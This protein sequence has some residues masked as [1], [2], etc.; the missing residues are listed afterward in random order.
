MNF[1][2]ALD[3]YRSGLRAFLNGVNNLAPHFSTNEPYP[4]QDGGVEEDDKLSRND[5]EFREANRGELRKVHL[6]VEQ[7]QNEF[8]IKISSSEFLT[9]VQKDNLKSHIENIHFNYKIPDADF[10]K[11]SF[12]IGE[13]LLETV[14]EISTQFNERFN[15]YVF[16]GPRNE[17]YL[18]DPVDFFISYRNSR[19]TVNIPFPFLMYPYFDADQPMS[20][21][22]GALGFFIGHEIGHSI[23]P[24]S[25]YFDEDSIDV[26][27]K[28]KL[29]LISQ[30]DGYSID[31]GN[32]DGSLTLGENWSD[33][34][35]MECA[36]NAF[37]NK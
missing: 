10:F 30:Y 15:S 24:Y 23:D 9:D 14:R 13:N 29:D 1:N 16:E 6:M 36:F 22:Y 11:G 8:F 34:I 31:Y 7:I 18:I 12:T 3:T 26:F 27:H 28:A 33:I 19:N 35:G 32:V 4:L 25:W 2:D 37:V 5:M 17:K 20:L 21:N